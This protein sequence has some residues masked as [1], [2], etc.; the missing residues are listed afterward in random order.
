MSS[1]RTRALR[2]RKDRTKLQ[3]DFSKEGMYADMNDDNLG[4]ASDDVN[5]GNETDPDSL[6]NQE[7]ANEELG[8]ESKN[9]E[10]NSSEI[11]HF[12]ESGSGEIVN[13]P[14]TRAQES[15]QD[16]PSTGSD[17]DDISDDEARSEQVG[18]APH[19]DLSEF[20]DAS[21]NAQESTLNSTTT[22]ADSTASQDTEDPDRVPV[23][24]TYSDD[25]VPN[26][27]GAILM[28]ARE[29]LGMSQREVAHQ[30]NLR[31]N[32]VSDIEHDRLN[33]PTAVPFASLHIGHYAKL[34][35]INPDLLVSLYKDCVKANV[36]AQADFHEQNEH[37]NKK[38]LS[39]GVKLPLYIFA[40]LGLIAITAGITAAVMSQHDNDTDGAL[41]IEDTIEPTEDAKGN[42]VMDMENSKIKTNI[43]EH[44][45]PGVD[46]NTKMAQEQ[47]TGTEN[48]EILVD[49]TESQREVVN[50]GTQM[51]LKVNAA[52]QT[53]DKATDKKEGPKEQ[54][55]ALKP[56]EL[57][58]ANG[59]KTETTN[60]KNTAEVHKTETVTS[61]TPEI[62]EPPKS[63]NETV[64]SQNVSLDKNPK[65]VTKSVKFSGKR[66]P[67]E[68]M[69]NVTIR[70]QGDVYLKVSGNGRILKQG[71]Y[72]KGDTLKITGIPPLKIAVS[73]ASLIKVSYMGAALSIPKSKQVSFALPT[74]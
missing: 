13:E 6:G 58:S 47:L 66:D 33:Q 28:H 5:V 65:D 39:A 44:D 46:K 70:V 34:V 8:S 73:D 31:V 12:S 45:K 23:S 17:S 71:A 2:N 35:N 54:Q 72:K 21:E 41:V 16:V 15:S 20:K 56:V 38:G 51:P 55:T 68:S 19:D 3:N 61:V 9:Q 26:R 30:L 60:L 69:N 53:K 64:V 62:T 40:G 1:K 14:M 7:L 37:Q 50:T 32:T 43:V 67:F 18:T 52:V 10:L 22:S 25:E 11:S 4:T 48:A 24:T 74:R 36:Q 27:P 57:E 29:M 59:E 42:L 49:R 63:E